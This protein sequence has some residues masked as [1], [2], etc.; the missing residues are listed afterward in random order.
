[1]V[2]SHP[3]RPCDG[4]FAALQAVAQRGPAAGDA[5]VRWLA[6]HPAVRFV[7]SEL[8]EDV[9]QTVALTLLGRASDILERLIAKNPSLRAGE[10]A[11]R[12]VSAY[13]AAMLRNCSQDQR[14]CWSSTSLSADPV[15]IRTPEL[16]LE[17]GEILCALEAAMECALQTSTACGQVALRQLRAL[18]RGEA[19]MEDLVREA[20]GST[21]S[22]SAWS[23]ARDRVYKRHRRARM[24]LVRALEHLES[25]GRLGL[26]VAARASEAVDAVFGLRQP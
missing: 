11:D 26:G 1:V 4:S 16:W 12:I 19:E 14:R 24:E 20:S 18:A 17:I 25:Q 10:T 21:R 5:L 23:R 2:L 3:L 13:V 9:V 8:R 7:P 22:A 6:A 15:E